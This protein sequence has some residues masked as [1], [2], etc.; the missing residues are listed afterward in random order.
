MSTN[1]PRRIDRDTAEQL[2]TG[3]VGGPSAGPGASLTGPDGSTGRTGSP[4]SEAGPGD[5]VARVLAAAAAPAT[6]GELAGEEA[7]LVAFREARLASAAVPAAPAPVRRRSMATATL[8]RAFSTKAAA[9][10]LGATALGGVAVA[11]GTGNL[12][13]P[14]GGGS[15]QPRR[16]AVAPDT[17]APSA[18]TATRSGAP[19]AR[20]TAPPSSPGPIGGLSGGTSSGSPSRPGT[21]PGS[22]AAADPTAAE[23]PGQEK[24]PKETPARTPGEGR[25][26]SAP[27]VHAA[28]CKLFDDRAGKGE[29]PRLLAADPQFGAL[30]AAAGGP[31]KVADYCAR[32][33]RGVGDDDHQDD[34]GQGSGGSGQGSGAGASR[35][36]SGSGSGSGRSG[37]D[38]QGG[39][40]QVSGGQGGTNEDGGPAAVA[41]GS[42]SGS[43]PGD[44]GT[45]G[46]GDGGPVRTPRT[47]T[48]PPAADPPAG[49]AQD[50]TAGPDSTPGDRR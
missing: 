48:V 30:V 13:V 24:R 31:D 10:V 6:G 16:G 32:A 14:L 45:G 21:A 50:R 12:P 4:R 20:P 8:T 46:T 29:R 7:A 23:P 35:P 49:P 38:S 41:G 42:G 39:S 47:A 44:A 37:A 9:V 11:A 2:L 17:S 3:A 40:S 33:L 15:D 25:N 5:R 19:T 22:P 28:L 1:R 43:G 36:G 18:T 26:S 34:S 27:A